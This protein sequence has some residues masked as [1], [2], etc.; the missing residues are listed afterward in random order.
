MSPSGLLSQLIKKKDVYTEKLLSVCNPKR[1][2]TS[3]HSYRLL[4]LKDSDPF[5]L[6][7]PVSSLACTVTRWGICH[8]EWFIF[9]QSDCMLV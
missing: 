3:W 7:V 1:V 4:Y 8:H 6:G 9:L 5:P 2:C